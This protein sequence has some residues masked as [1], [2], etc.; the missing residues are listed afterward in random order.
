M[1]DS[2]LNDSVV[3]ASW[4]Y[5]ILINKICNILIMCSLVLRNTYS[6]IQFALPK[7]HMQMQL[8]QYLG[9]FEY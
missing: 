2:L 5:R 6:Q 7:Q 8:S 9:L 1:K 4:N 3:L